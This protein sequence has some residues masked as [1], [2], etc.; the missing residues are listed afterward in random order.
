MSNFIIHYDYDLGLILP[1][2]NYMAKN[3]GVLFYLICRSS[4]TLKLYFSFLDSIIAILILSHI[5][6][7]PLIADIRLLII[8]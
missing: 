7:D 8:S 4:V 3:T 1:K 5:V 6:G 2:Y